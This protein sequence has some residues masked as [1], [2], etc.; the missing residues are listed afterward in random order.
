MLAAL[1]RG[2]PHGSPLESPSVRRQWGGECYLP[3]SHES[4]PQTVRGAEA[5]GKGP[6]AEE[7]GKQTP[8]SGRKQ[9]GNNCLK[10]VFF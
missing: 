10:I 9:L 1:R 8:E 3:A 5:Q 7:A 6:R 2:A 4:P